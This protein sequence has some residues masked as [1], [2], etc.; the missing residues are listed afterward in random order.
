MQKELKKFDDE[1]AR[2]NDNKVQLEDTIAKLTNSFNQAE[3]T[4]KDSLK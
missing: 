3:A 2:L 4:N 1:I